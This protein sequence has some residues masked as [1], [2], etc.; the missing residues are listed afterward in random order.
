[1]GGSPHDSPA[2]QLAAMLR[3]TLR[4]PSSDGAQQP[5]VGIPETLAGGEGQGIRST[6]IACWLHVCCKPTSG[7]T[8]SWEGRDIARGY[9]DALVAA[10]PST[11]WGCTLQIENFTVMPELSTSE[12]RF[13]CIGTTK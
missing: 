9:V 7:P 12:N 2:K 4:S 3:S 11:G 6:S 13:T 8:M 5:T 10:N 1:M